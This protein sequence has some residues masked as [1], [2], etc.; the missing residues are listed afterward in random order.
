MTFFKIFSGKKPKIAEKRA[1]I[2]DH[3]EKN[4]LVGAEL[5]KLGFELEFKQ[6]S[7]AD[8]LVKDIAIERKTINDLKTSIINKRLVNQLRELQQYKNRF[9]IVEGIDSS[10]YEGIIHE[11]ALRGFLIS[12][13]RDYEIPVLYTLNEKDTARYLSLMYLKGERGQPSLRASKIIHTEKEKIQYILEGF[14]SIGPV[15]AQKLIHHF[16]SIKAIANASLEEISAVIGDKAKTVRT[17][18]DYH[19]T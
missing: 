16:K 14:P 11:N 5:V 9:L 4:S 3:R 7:V 13:G 17:L 2:V 10:L 15:T 12:I 19:V 1:I 6:L 18:F 8:Y